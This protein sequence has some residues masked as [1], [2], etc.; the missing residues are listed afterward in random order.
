[1]LGKVVSLGALLGLAVLGLTHQ[2]RQATMPLQAWLDPLAVANE[3]KIL[4]VC[5][6]TQ[7]PAIVEAMRGTP[8][9]ADARIVGEV[10]EEPAGLAVLRSTIRGERVISMPVG[11]DL[12]RIC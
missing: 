7:A 5:P 10:T 1:M 2:A 6:A 12:P 3:G 4:V 8:H 9:G 11:E